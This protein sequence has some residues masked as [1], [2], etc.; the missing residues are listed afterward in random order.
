MRIPKIQIVVYVVHLYKLYNE[1]CPSNRPSDAFY[2]KPKVN[3]K[4]DGCW[5]NARAVGHNI[6]AG[7]VKRLCQEAG[8]TGH[9]TN[10]SLRSTA[11]TRLFEA[12]VDEQ[13]IMLRTGHSTTSGVRSYKRVGEKLRSIT[14]DVF[15][16]AKKFKQ[17]SECLKGVKQVGEHVESVENGNRFP[18][19]VQPDDKLK[20]PMLS[21]AGATNFTSTST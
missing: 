1:K 16:G 13:L 4:S 19:A 20:L 9:F 7:T 15:N 8:L 12:G 21:F 18:G 5:Y 6:L 17:D 10:H 2:L 11:A 3:H 14:S